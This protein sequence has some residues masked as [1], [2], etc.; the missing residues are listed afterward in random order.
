MAEGAGVKVCCWSCRRYLDPEKVGLDNRCVDVETC[1]R[2]TAARLMPKRIPKRG[3]T[4][5]IG[6]PQ[7]GEKATGAAVKSATSEEV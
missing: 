1:R 6:A 2:V 3:A 7:F 4:Q 5:Y